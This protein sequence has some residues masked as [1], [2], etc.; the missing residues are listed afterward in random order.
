[1]GD[2]LAEGPHEE[3]GDEAAE[4]VGEHDRRPRGVQAS[5]RPEEEA[6]AD[7]AADRDHVDLAAGQPLVVAGIAVVDDGAAVGERL[8]A[9]VFVLGVGHANPLWF[10]VM[11]RL[12]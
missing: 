8:L 7:G 1:V 2:E 9:D 5:A 6:D 12:N 4:G 3:E 11:Q 10:R